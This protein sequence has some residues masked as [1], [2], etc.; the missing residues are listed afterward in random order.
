MNNLLCESNLSCE[1]ILQRWKHACLCL[2]SRWREWRQ[3]KMFCLTES[4][5]SRTCKVGCG[6]HWYIFAPSIVVFVVLFVIVRPPPH[7]AVLGYHGITLAKD[8]YMIY[9]CNIYIYICEYIFIYKCIHD[10]GYCVFLL[11]FSELVTSSS[12]FS[13]PFLRS[14]STQDS[15]QSQHPVL[16]PSCHGVTG[17]HGCDQ[18][19]IESCHTKRAVPSP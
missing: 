3:A 1:S 5:Y 14:N 16:T 12:L 19:A 7:D 10:L 4:L 15:L 6:S 2:C 8:A 11:S 13:Q 18:C 9:V 17:C